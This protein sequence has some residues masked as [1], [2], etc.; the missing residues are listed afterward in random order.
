MGTREYPLEA[1]DGTSAAGRAGHDQAVY[2]L[3]AYIADQLLHNPYILHGVYLS[4]LVRDASTRFTEL[5]EKAIYH[6]VRRL[7]L[8]WHKEGLIKLTKIK[9][10]LFAIPLAKFYGRPSR[11]DSIGVASK[12]QTI[13][14]PVTESRQA[15]ARTRRRIFN[16]ANLPRRLHPHRRA[17][18]DFLRQTLELDEKGW[19]YINDLFRFYLDDTRYKVVVLRSLEDLS[20]LL[21]PYSHRFWRSRLKEILDKYEEVW[22]A[23][24][25]RYEVGVF[26]TI[27]S[28]PKKETNLYDCS[29]EMSRRFNALMS[30]IKKKVKRKRLPYICVPE[31]QD[32]GRLHLHV[33]IFGIGRIA[34]KKSE[35]TPELERLG[36]GKINYI[37]KIVKRDGKWVWAKKRPRD[38]RRNPQDYLKKYLEKAII[39]SFLFNRNSSGAAFETN[40]SIA[41]M[42]LAMYWAT[43]KRFFTYSYS[44][45]RAEDE[46]PD[47]FMIGPKLYEYVGT[48]NL[49]DLP[50]QI[51]KNAL[52][53]ELY[54]LLLGVPP[55]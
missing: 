2:G 34:D 3:E 46:E 14:G 6:R 42:K 48:F 9:G 29:R 53:P 49:W 54:Y 5:S 38:T 10:M 16:S 21:L 11:V 50:E 51:L 36:F 31:F 47:E 19:R 55:P 44:A 39:G 28:D 40:Y 27:T 26:L 8:R 22:R 17:A 25:S 45:L 20:F 13:G 12:T 52:N 7:L 32:N 23:L 33:V 4:Y 30:W 43:G 37:Y 35:L 41:L 18:I 1:V 15:D 24:S